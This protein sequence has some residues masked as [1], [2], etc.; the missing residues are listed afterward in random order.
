MIPCLVFPLVLLTSN[1]IAKVRACSDE[2]MYSLGPRPSTPPVFDRLQYAN[3]EGEGLGDLVT[4]G[5]QW[6]H[7]RLV[8]VELFLVISV[9]V[10]SPDCLQG[11][12]NTAC[13]SGMPVT[14]LYVWSGTTPRMSTL[15]LPDVRH[16]T[17]SPKTL[18]PLV[19][20]VALT[21]CIAFHSLVCM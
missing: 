9:Q 16:A 6:T 8:P 12:I 13:S 18:S 4:F 7:G 14:G 15:C 20:M 19:V 1:Y 17:K 5:G 21:D 11:S 10:L 3:T 2:R